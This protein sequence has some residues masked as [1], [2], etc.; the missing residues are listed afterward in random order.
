MHSGRVWPLGE[1]DSDGNR[2]SLR[3]TNVRLKRT[4][5]KKLITDTARCHVNT[6]CRFYFGQ[7]SPY[8]VTGCV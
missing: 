1:G 6:D 2:W 3:E 7:L 5:P 4:L 8:L